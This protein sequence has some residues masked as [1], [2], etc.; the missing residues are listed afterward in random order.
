MACKKEEIQARSSND[1]S[2]NQSGLVESSSSTKSSFLVFK[3]SE[4]FNVLANADEQNRKVLMSKF[5]KDQFVSYSELRQLEKSSNDLVGDEFLSNILNK[6]L[7]V[8]I[9]NYLYKVNKSIEKVFVLPV[10]NLNEY[11]D[12][13]SENKLNKHIRVFSTEDNVIEL[14]ESGASGEKALICKD[15]GVASRNHPISYY[16]KIGV[17]NYVIKHDL[18]H[19]KFGIYFSLYVLSETNQP[20]GGKFKYEFSN[21]GTEGQW[22]IRCGSWGSVAGTTSSSF[23]NTSW[24]KKEIHNSSTNFNKYNIRVRVYYYSGVV[25]NANIE[26]VS[27]SNWMQIRVNL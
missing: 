23:T 8:Q 2:S 20:F 10:I 4:E 9:G 13:V 7:I 18:R 27:T 25:N 24:Y 17:N 12:L 5:E 14:A 6:D 3:S 11:S 21:S 15:D 16:H 19:R 22:R 1:V 26:D